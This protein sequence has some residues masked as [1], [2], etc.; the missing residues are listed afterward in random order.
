MDGRN[1]CRQGIQGLEGGLHA[2]SLWERMVRVKLAE[3]AV[4]GVSLGLSP[5]MNIEKLETI[6]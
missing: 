5:P 4:E 1:Q 2:D 6:R 3:A